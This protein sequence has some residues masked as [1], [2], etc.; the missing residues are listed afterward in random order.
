[1][2]KKNY[3]EIWY[4]FFIILYTFFQSKMELTNLVGYYGNG[5]YNGKKKLLDNAMRF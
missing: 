2:I 4:S 3:F 5:A 1:M